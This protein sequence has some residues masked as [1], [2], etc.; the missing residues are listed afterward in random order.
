MGACRRRLPP[1]AGHALSRH[2]GSDL[3][4]FIILQDSHV[5]QSQPELQTT[6]DYL[7]QKFSKI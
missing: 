3:D 7:W 4:P 1:N 5:P 6:K 2:A